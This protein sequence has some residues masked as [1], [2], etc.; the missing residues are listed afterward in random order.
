MI[1]RIG[2]LQPKFTPTNLDVVVRLQSQEA[3]NQDRGGAD[4]A[5]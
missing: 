2:A 5:R 3:A 1:S 4:D